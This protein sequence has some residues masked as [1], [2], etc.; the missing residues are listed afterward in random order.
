MRNKEG[1]VVS[2]EVIASIELASN[3]LQDLEFDELMLRMREISRLYN[4]L[5]EIYAEVGLVDK[6]IQSYT[7]AINHYSGDPQYRRNIGVAFYSVG[8]YVA[9]LYN[10]NF[11]GVLAS[12]PSEKQEA[13]ILAAEVREY[14]PQTVTVNEA[15][16]VP[17]ELSPVLGQLGD[18]LHCNEEFS[19]SWLSTRHSPSPPPY[20]SLDAGPQQQDDSN[21]T[22]VRIDFHRNRELVE[23]VARSSMTV[24]GL[25]RLGNWVGRENER[26]SVEISDHAS[27]SL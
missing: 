12:N 16:P 23:S 7:K 25:L 14:L 4:E 27:R 22:P 2:S 5:G 24:I 18:E 15:R 1:G 6:A 19:E 13:T 9:A 26:R 20:L 11:Y 17:E 21:A 8:K 3:Q 10:L